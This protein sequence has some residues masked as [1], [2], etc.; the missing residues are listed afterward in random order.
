MTN[1]LLSWMEGEPVI[2][3]MRTQGERTDETARAVARLLETTMAERGCRRLLLDL[4]SAEFTSDEFSV[5][6][7]TSIIAVSIPRPSRVALF[8][9]DAQ[10]DAARVSESMFRHAGHAAS[11]CIS[12]DEAVRFLRVATGEENP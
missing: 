8:A 1:N 2:A 7:G 11:T 9:L 3:L 6:R 4:S 12:M 10:L 5:M